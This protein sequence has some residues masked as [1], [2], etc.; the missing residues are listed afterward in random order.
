MDLALFSILTKR[1]TK[2]IGKTT[3]RKERGFILIIIGLQLMFGWGVALLMGGICLVISGGV[4]RDT[5]TEPEKIQKPG[6]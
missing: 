4:L 2:A 3:K 5:R 6:N 1:C